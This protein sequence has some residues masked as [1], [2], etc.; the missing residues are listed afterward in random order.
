[1]KYGILGDGVNLASRLEEL[2]KRYGTSLLVSKAVIDSDL[3]DV[4]FVYRPI[5]FVS[6]KGRSKGKVL[7][8]HR[9]VLQLVELSLAS[10]LMQHLTAFHS[11]AQERTFSRFW[12]HGKR[13][14][15]TLKLW[16]I[17]KSIHRR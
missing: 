3:V 5:D 8:M 6:V 17:L 2:N 10:A 9:S 15:R 4:H 1:M 16:N 7:F 13:P 12:K 14:T 11:N